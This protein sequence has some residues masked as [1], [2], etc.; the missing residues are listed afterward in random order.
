MSTHEQLLGGPSGQVYQ[1]CR[2]PANA[3]YRD[4][5]T[6]HGAAIGE[7]LAQHGALGRFCVDFVATRSSSAN[8]KLLG[9]EINLRRSGTSHP[10]SLLHSLVPGHYDA[11]TGSWVVEDGTER[12]YR[13]TDHLTAPT[14][15]GRPADD[16][17]DAVRAAGLEL[18]PVTGIGA[19]LHMLIGL[20]IDGLIGLTAIGRST[21]HAEQIHRSA[22]AALTGSA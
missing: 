9:L 12:C 20:D 11:E 15:R 1:G 18:D 16:V 19:V 13:S 8:W 17:I 10:L 21:Q 3:D 7:L 2:F 5:L 22:V 14:W 4:A 6:A